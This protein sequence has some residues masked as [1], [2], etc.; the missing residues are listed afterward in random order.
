MDLP[1]SD[2]EPRRK[3][4]DQKQGTIQSQVGTDDREFPVLFASPQ[5]YL[6]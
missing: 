1:D 6:E 5:I 4:N 2:R 3:W